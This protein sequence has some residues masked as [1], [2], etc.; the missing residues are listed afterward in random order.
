MRIILLTKNK[1]NVI[2]WQHATAA[3][4]QAGDKMPGY[5][6]P[7]RYCNA[8][9]PP[10]ATVCPS[11][12]KVNPVGPIRCPSCRS[13]IDRGSKNC[14]HCGLSLEV[15]CPSCGKKTFLENYCSHCDNMLVVVC[16]NPKCKTEQRIGS[17]KCIKCGKP[18]KV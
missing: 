18:L 17:E 3:Q 6:T 5:K 11:C 12:G 10:D 7:C 15:V 9:T 13:P 4:L 1:A 14:S 8:L 16:M 2:E